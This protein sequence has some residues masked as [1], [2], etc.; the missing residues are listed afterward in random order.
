[1]QE[2]FRKNFVL[3]S[4]VAKEKKYAQE[5]LGLLAR[6]GDLGS[7]RI[8]KRWYTTWE[9]FSEFEKDIVAKKAEAVMPEIEIELV[10][11]K[12]KIATPVPLQVRVK[13]PTIDLRKVART[14]I[15][16]SEKASQES[17][18]EFEVLNG[19][20]NLLAG[21]H[22]FS[23][24]FL[25][26]RAGEPPFLPKFAFAVSLVLL[27]FLLFQ[28]GFF[29]REEIMEIAR[30]DSLASIW[31][32]GLA[33]LAGAESGKVAGAY[34]TKVDLSS[35]KN[36]S[37]GY[38]ENKGDKVKENVSLARVMLRAA[39]ERNNEQRSTSPEAEQAR[40]GAGNDQ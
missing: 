22:G 24:S 40:Y 8:G 30:L 13:L 7:V 31:R 17:E 5:Y 33:R 10:G 37:A 39:M 32:S 16:G 23:P 36:L 1:M 34:D 14:N 27:F 38:L 15:Q 2:D 12:E 20:R 11:E 4:K 28:V 3:L 35:V 6:R 18:R 19:A 25:P 9:W 26:E 29:Y 21:R